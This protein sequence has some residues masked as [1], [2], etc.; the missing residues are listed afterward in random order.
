MAV[1]SLCSPSATG[2]GS[3]G[4]L[5][6]FV[7]HCFSVFPFHNTTAATCLFCTTY[8]TCNPFSYLQLFLV[9]ATAPHHTTPHHCQYLPTPDLIHY[10]FN[11]KEKKIS[12]LWFL[13]FLWPFLQFLVHSGMNQIHL[14]QVRNLCM[15]NMMYKMQRN[16]SKK[17]VM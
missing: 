13:N 15:Q 1:P 4:G 9:S 7:F 14:F 11:Q 3:T 17:T 12:S 6:L 16:L 2:N 5:S 10:L 8:S